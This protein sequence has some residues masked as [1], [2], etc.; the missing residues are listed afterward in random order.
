MADSTSQTDAEKTGTEETQEQETQT[1]TQE[2]VD[3]IV[4][5]RL[6]RAK[7]KKP[8]D[9]DDLK[10]KAERLDALEAENQSET[11]RM[12]AEARRE[13]EAEVTERFMTER[14]L[15]KIEVAA[16]GRFQDVE[17]ARLRLGAR[18]AEFVD[19]GAVDTEAIKAAVDEV[20][21]AA[22]HLAVKQGEE[23]NTP[24]GRDVGLGTKGK[25]GNRA[26][27][28]PGLGRLEIAYDQG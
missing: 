7:P 17:D 19:D 24:R 21:E 2:D 14:V 10:A 18:A 1:F 27:V 6:A 15:D 3:R 5:E 16:A 22:P 12:V 8:A 11:E 26:N 28:K 25:R 23:R 4:Q 20:L 9:Y 13:V